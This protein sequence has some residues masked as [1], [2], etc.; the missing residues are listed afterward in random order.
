M[1]IITREEAVSP[2]V[3]VM[4]MLVVT[5]IIAAVV[6]SFSGSLANSNDAA[7]KVS[8]SVNLNEQYMS[9]EHLGGEIPFP[10]RISGSSPTTPTLTAPWRNMNRAS[11]AILSRWAV[12]LTE[13]HGCRC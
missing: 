10:Q 13:R 7:L 4:L 12:I 9:F 6:S 8:I 5:I 2:V 3:G 11:T 1:N